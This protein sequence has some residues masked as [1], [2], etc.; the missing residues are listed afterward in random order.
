MNTFKAAIFDLGGTLIDDR[1]MVYV[2]HKAA[3]SSFNVKP[4]T[5]DE[6]DSSFTSNW[7]ELYE[8][9]GLRIN[10]VQV[11]EK[12]EKVTQENNLM[13][14]I[15]PYNGA[16][17]ALERIKKKMRIALNTSYRRKELDAIM[18]IVLLPKFDAIATGD[19]LAELKPHPRSINEI[20]SALN[21]S[22]ADCV[23]IGDT[24]A[25]IL[26]GK[27]AGSRTVAVTWGTNHEKDLAQLNPD[28]I[29]Y[30][31]QDIL[32]FLGV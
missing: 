13:K 18:K 4:P 5:K 15:K 31:W 24:S 3:L 1:E 21:V 17:E 25:D 6:F 32:N 10:P 27:N 12:F 26:C 29:A 23:M 19:N 30:S 9:H 11:M 2:A 14:A 28:I 8:K 16:M 20:C 22:P 7:V